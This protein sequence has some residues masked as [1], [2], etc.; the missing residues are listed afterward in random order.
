MAE[1]EHW[2]MWRERCALARCTES[3]Q[4]DLQGF[5]FNRYT[6]FLEKCGQPSSAPDAFD[7]WHGFESHLALGHQRTA[8]AWKEWLF[9]RGGKKPTLDCIQGGATL[10]MRDV[11]RYHLRREH[12][13]KWMLSLHAPIGAKSE[14]E[15]AA[16]LA[17]LL[18]D[19]SDPLEAIEQ[20][21]IT[22]CAQ[23]L[24]DEVSADLT[25]VEIVALITHQAGKT[26]N[27]P[28]ALKLADCSKSSL[29][30]ALH[31][32]LYKMAASIKTALPNEIATVRI[33]V[34][35]HILEN[36]TRQTVKKLEKDYPRFFQYIKEE[37]RDA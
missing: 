33:A 19:P 32:G 28:A 20:H 14:S 7:A 21:E 8:K 25:L 6:R 27:H 24:T 12:A 29:H 23:K 17:D 18:P 31:Q 34:A 35:K 2:Q 37:K 13:P 1:L 26:L 10:I 16:K 3:A 22:V 30:N 4:Q 36:I 11:V 9:A 5:A 15:H